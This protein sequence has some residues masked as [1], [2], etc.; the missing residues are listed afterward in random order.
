M[1]KAFT[2][3]EIL[4]VVTILSVLA[5]SVFVALNP[6]QRIKDAQDA[7]RST[8]LDSILTAIHQYIVDNNGSLPTG[9][10]AGMVQK[11]LGTSTGTPTCVI[12]DVPAGCSIAAAG[13]CVDLATPL[14]PYLKSIPMDPVAGAATTTRYAVQVNSNGIVTVT[15]CDADTPPIAVSR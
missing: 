8:D 14:A 13:D 9:L 2:L 11:Q 10:T 5:V 12:S 4:V 3:I 7:R 6:G 1:K 15:G